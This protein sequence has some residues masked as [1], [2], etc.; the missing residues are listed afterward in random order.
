MKESVQDFQKRRIK[1]AVKELEDE[2]IDVWKIMRKAGIR[3]NFYNDVSKEISLY[4]K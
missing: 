2:E 1:W 3:E 4:V